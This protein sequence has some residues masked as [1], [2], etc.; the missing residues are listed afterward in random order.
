M[1]KLVNGIIDID[2]NDV[3]YFEQWALTAI[4]RMKRY[5]YSITVGY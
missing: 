3:I 1:K 5:E 4:S 2:S